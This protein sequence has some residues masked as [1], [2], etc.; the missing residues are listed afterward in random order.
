MFTAKVE[1][2]PFTSVAV[3]VYEPA[4]KELNVPGTTCTPAAGEIEYVIEPVPPKLE[5]MAI[6]V[7]SHVGLAEYNKLRL[8]AAAG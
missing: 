1:V 5:T 2:H 4:G 8:T 3:I 7:K 6:P